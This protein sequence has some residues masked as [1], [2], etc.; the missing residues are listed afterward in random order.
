MLQKYSYLSLAGLP[1]LPDVIFTVYT[2]L[3]STA[4]ESYRGPSL[5]YSAPGFFQKLDGVKKS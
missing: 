4:D 2:P 5:R 3:T 1:P